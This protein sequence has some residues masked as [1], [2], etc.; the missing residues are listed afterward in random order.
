MPEL[1][2]VETVVRRLRASLIGRTFGDVCVSW[3]R[4]LQIPPEELGLR[5]PG[6]RIVAIDRRGKYLVFRLS[7]GDNL[8]IHLKMTGDLVVASA[9]EPAHPHDRIVFDLD[10]GLQLRFRDPRKFGR[11]YLTDR[12]ADV[13][14]RLGPEPLDERFSAQ[15]FLGLFDRRSGRIKPLLLD[16][17]FIAG[18]G[19]IYADEALFLA[20]IR[21][22]RSSS[23]LSEEDKQR[24]YQA[25]REVLAMAIEQQGS[26]LGDKTHRG[27]KYQD[28]FLVYGR[29]EQPCCRCGSLIQRIRLGQRSAHFCPVCQQ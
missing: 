13:L 21:P 19:N 9:A 20:G 11:V 22:E 17:H 12:S 2:E 28:R 4:M 23:S 3:E 18:L 14:G 16:Q 15:D 6:Q 25:I 29:S 24:L 27:G 10:D 5:L 8:I 1:P 7:Q 26:S